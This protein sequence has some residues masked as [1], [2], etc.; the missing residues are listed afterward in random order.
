MILVCG[1]LHL[2]VVV[3][4]PRLPQLDETLVG[5]AVRYAAGG[6]GGNQAIAAARMGA[7][8]A[9]AGRVGSDAFGVQLLAALVA[10]GVATGAITTG[11]GASGMSV[12]IEQAGGEYGAV[13]VSG[14]NLN[15]S[16][17]SLEIPAAT[18]IL[19]LQDRKS[20]V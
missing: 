11:P 19:I 17:D 6:K 8:V 12:A 1:A 15:L 16:A 10:A 7:Q 3:L 2:D 5:Q 13:I 14:E 18:R 9:M 4:A 20:V